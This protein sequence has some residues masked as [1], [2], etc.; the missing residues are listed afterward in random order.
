M[1]EGEL[2]WK[3]WTCDPRNILCE[4]CRLG[5]CGH[6]TS[7]GWSGMSL[8]WSLWKCDLRSKAWERGHPGACGSVIS[9]QRPGRGV[10]L[11]TVDV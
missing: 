1:G 8:P 4:G 11:E 3:L 6:M 7:G 2:P 9:G 10:T 5:Y